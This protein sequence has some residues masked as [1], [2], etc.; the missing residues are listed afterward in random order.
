MHNYGWA[1]PR[2]KEGKQEIGKCKKKK[3]KISIE[4]NSQIRCAIM[5]IPFS[6]TCRGDCP[7]ACIYGDFEREYKDGK[8]NSVE[9][10]CCRHSVKCD[11]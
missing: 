8:Q 11:K 2:G 6:G 7:A 4:K 10:K 9:A 1:L 5:Y 3:K